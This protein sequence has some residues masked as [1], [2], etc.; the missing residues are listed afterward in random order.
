M[1]ETQAEP[2]QLES[3]LLDLIYSAVADPHRWM[4]V[5]VGVS[6]NL[7]AMG[8][9][10]AHVPPP[11][12]GKSPAQILGRLPEKASAL[13][14]ERKQ[15]RGAAIKTTKKNGRNANAQMQCEEDCCSITDEFPMNPDTRRTIVPSRGSPLSSAR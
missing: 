7:G 15:N 5:F 2:Q 1:A 13:F 3:K 8:G 4:D 12:S 10:I 6:D 14:R 11:S 9:M